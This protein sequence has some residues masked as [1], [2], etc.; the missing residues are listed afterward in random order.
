MIYI[1]NSKKKKKE[2]N[3]VNHFWIFKLCIAIYGNHYKNKTICIYNQKLYKQ[4]FFLTS[5][6]KQINY[7]EKK[8]L[9]VL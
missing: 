8:D 6:L 2:L 9:L 7:T 5:Y 3:Q 1:L 4:M